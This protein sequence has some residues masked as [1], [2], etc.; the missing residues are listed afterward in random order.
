MPLI[1]TTLSVQCSQEKKETLAL[2]LSHVLAKGTSKPE[3][4]VQSI[5]E[6][7]AVISFSGE[8]KDSALVEV[9]GI[10]GLTAA[11]N[12]SLSHHIC[13]AIESELGISASSVYINFLE[14]SGSHWGHKGGTFA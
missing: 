12:K 11:V 6:D 14:V 7:C 3:A 2:L 9:R 5:I 13:D 4:Y 1:K 8:I 10:G